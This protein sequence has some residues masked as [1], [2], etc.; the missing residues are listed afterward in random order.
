MN[1][2]S[3]LIVKSDLMEDKKLVIADLKPDI[4]WNL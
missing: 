4:D 2:G 1:R 3:K